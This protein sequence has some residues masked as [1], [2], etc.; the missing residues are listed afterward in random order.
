[1]VLR[2]CMNAIVLI[3][4]LCSCSSFRYGLT[5]TKSVQLN[6]FRNSWNFLGLQQLKL[7]TNAQSSDGNLNPETSLLS[8]LKGT[9]IYLVGMMGS[10]KTSIGS[11]L[12]EKLNYRSL[13]TDEIAEFMI[14]MPI[15]QFFA[16]GNETEFRQLEYQILMELSQ[17][18]RVVIST[19]G[20][21]I[22]KNENWGLLRHGI[23]IF[24]DVE[25]E[26]IYN[27]LTANPKEVAKRP[28]LR[29]N[30]DPLDA[31]RKL[32]DSRREKYM[33]ADVYVKIPSSLNTAEATDL[34]IK[35]TLDFIAAN[36]PRWQ[37]WKE[38]KE[39][40]ALEMAAMTNPT[41]ISNA[42]KVA[43]NGGSIQYVKL[44]DI[45]SGK[46]KL[47]NVSNGEN[48]SQKQSVVDRSPGKGFIPT[49][50]MSINSDENN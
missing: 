37:T 40:K 36:P 27:R 6:K 9:C 20:G 39:K 33:A 47:P 38:E 8:K 48:I 25:P 35:S 22:L 46:V 32:D 19:G 13:D 28:L 31:L 11:L 50:P 29:D 16:N 41:A 24:I 17:Y 44:S 49:K 3:F 10:G 18:T 7:N 21:I 26:T 14:E 42:K 2:F 23:V 1:M 5:S 34:V 45:K 12:A 30:V 43:E 4:Y 15:S